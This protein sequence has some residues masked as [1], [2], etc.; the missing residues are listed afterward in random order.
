VRTRASPEIVYETHVNAPPARDERKRHA[1]DERNKL[2][3]G[4]RLGALS[5]K[6]RALAAAEALLPLCVC[7]W[8]H[9]MAYALS[10]VSDILTGKSKE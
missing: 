9:G 4:A 8:W 2:I 6:Q 10:A 7:Q 1:K 5:A 3:I